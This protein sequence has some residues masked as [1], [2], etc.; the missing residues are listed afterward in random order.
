L[1]THV[2]LSLSSIKWYQSKGIDALQME[3]YPEVWHRTGYASQTQ[4]VFHLWAQGL[5]QGDEYSLWV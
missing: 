4:V 3:R 1:F 2:A 5:N